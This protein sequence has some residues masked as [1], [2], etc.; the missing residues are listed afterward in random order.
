MMEALKDQF[1]RATLHIEN[2]RHQLLQMAQATGTPLTGNQVLG[3]VADNLYGSPAPIG[4][5]VPQAYINA[6]FGSAP[7]HLGTSAMNV[8]QFGSFSTH[9]EHDANSGPPGFSGYYNHGQDHAVA[10]APV[11]STSNVYQP[12]QHYQQPMGQ[13]QYQ[14]YYPPTATYYHY[15]A[16]MPTTGGAPAGSNH[17]NANAQPQGHVHA[18]VVSSNA[19]PTT[20]QGESTNS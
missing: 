20:H 14:S 3:T 6:Q 15:P 10:P 16:N 4:G 9:S 11:P 8:P 2:Q 18:A 17:G 7:Q 19:N 5:T 1:R 13:Y 12:Y